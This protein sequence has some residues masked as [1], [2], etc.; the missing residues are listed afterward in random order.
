MPAKT[1]AQQRM[2]PKQ[3]AKMLGYSIQH[4]RHKL[5][6]ENILTP[7]RDR[8]AARG[9]KVFVLRDEV[10]LAMTEGFEAVQAYRKK[11]G[12]LK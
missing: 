7:I 2:T 9:V 8:P 11:K 6:K 12:R 4:F 5:R 1:K 10:E 3:A